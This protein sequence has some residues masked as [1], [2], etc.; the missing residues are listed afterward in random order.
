MRARLACDQSLFDGPVNQAN[1]AMVGDMQ[2]FSQITNC[3]ALLVGKTFNSEQ[4]LM[5]AWGQT[6]ILGR[7][8]AEVQ[9]SAEMVTKCR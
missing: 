3:D 7:V 2:L 4:G 6:C 9:K 1:R 8:L 5:L